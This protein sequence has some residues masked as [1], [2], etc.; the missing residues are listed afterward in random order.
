MSTLNKFNCDIIIFTIMSTLL[1]IVIFPTE[2]Y[3]SMIFHL[4][5]SNSHNT[6]TYNGNVHDI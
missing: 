5:L 6:Y 1:C 4:L 2:S 3:S